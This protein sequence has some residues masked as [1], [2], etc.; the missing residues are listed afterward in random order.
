MENEQIHVVTA[1]ILVI[2]D[3]ILSGRTKDQN[4][5]YIASHLTEWGI[6]LKEV[7]IVPDEEDRIVEAVNALRTRYTYVFTSGGIGPTHDDITAESIAKAFGVPVHKHPKAMAA[8]EAHYPKGEFSEA[9]QRMA[10]VPLG[11]DLIDNKISIAPGF[12]M[13]NVHVMAGVPKIMQAMMQA[14]APSLERGT[15]IISQSVDLPRPESS[16]ALQLQQLQ[17]D[18]PQAMIGSYPQVKD[19]KFSTQIV[20][21]AR[22]LDVLQSALTDVRA[23][24]DA[25][26][27]RNS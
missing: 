6:D 23:A 19:G 8:M 14:L 16:I 24:V 11:A 22:K 15:K 20:V 12:I 3:E 13:E 5:G 7:R 26:M 21:R 10:R 2:G 17:H 9:R 4:I 18:H 25:A 27:K 1:A